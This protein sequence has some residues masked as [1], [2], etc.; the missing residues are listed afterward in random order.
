MAKKNDAGKDCFEGENAMLTLGPL[1]LRH[2]QTKTEYKYNTN[3]WTRENWAIW[4]PENSNFGVRITIVE[5]ENIA[6]GL[7]KFKLPHYGVMEKTGRIDTCEINTPTLC[8][9]ANEGMMFN[10]D[11]TYTK[12][13]ISPLHEI[14]KEE[15]KPILKLCASLTKQPK[16]I[17]ESYGKVEDYT[18]EGRLIRYDNNTS[19]EWSIWSLKQDTKNIYCQRL[20]SFNE[21]T[22]K[23]ESMRLES[24][25]MGIIDAI[26]AD[27]KKI[28]ISKLERTFEGIRSQLSLSVYSQKTKDVLG[29]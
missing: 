4:I 15:V 5:G 21:Y 6:F 28:H 24:S 20:L 12:I 29:M 9:G 7:Q 10:L 3:I 14:S 26:D 1:D 25:W 18:W 16:Q 17:E 2:Y 8:C 22:E 23:R 27:E 13:C 11:K 19:E